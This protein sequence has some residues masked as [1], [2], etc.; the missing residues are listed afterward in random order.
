MPMEENIDQRKTPRYTISSGKALFVFNHF[1]TRVGCVKDIS[2]GGLSFEYIDK[3]GRK[4]IPEVIDIFTNNEERV[5]MPAVP[6]KK[7]Y[8]TATLGK[9][10]PFSG[11]ETRRCGLQYGPLTID[12]KKQIAHLLESRLVKT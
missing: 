12:Q 7:I 11:L 5:F 4:C 2:Q 8:D 1:S 6:C 10:E 9:T 3:S